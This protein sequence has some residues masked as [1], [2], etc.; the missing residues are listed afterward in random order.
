M[1][2]HKVVPVSGVRDGLTRLYQYLVYLMVRHEVVPVYGVPDGLTQ[3]C[4]SI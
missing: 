2:R 1:V 3:G 4:T